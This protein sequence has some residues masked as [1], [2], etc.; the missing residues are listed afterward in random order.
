MNAQMNDD[1]DF[2]GAHI[3]QG[4]EALQ[5]FEHQMSGCAD[6]ECKSKRSLLASMI[7]DEVFI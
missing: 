4:M 7:G 5:E 2:G 6:L 3:I 1:I